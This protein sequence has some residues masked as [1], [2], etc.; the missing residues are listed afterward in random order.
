VNGSG[1][2]SVRKIGMLAMQIMLDMMMDLMNKIAREA[3]MILVKDGRR[4]LTVH[5][6]LQPP[7]ASSCASARTPIIALLCSR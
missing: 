7:R 5:M 4:S 2:I 6:T 3:S 1:N